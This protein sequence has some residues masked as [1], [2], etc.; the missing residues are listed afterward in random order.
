MEY[1]IV[2]YPNE[3]DVYV[4]DQLAGKTGD[5]LQIETGHHRFTLGTPL[6]Y[7]PAAQDVAVTGT[8]PIIPMEIEFA[9]TGAA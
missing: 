8:N 9:P 4:D 5:T 2:K 6:D 7:E 1:V 3:R